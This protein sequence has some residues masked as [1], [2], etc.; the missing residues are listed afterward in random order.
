MLED[1]LKNH[2]KYP[3]GTK[4][5]AIDFVVTEY[6]NK[7]DYIKYICERAST[8]LFNSIKDELTKRIEDEVQSAFNNRDYPNSSIKVHVNLPEELGKTIA[9]I[10]LIYTKETI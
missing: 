9:S 8:Q 1:I 6:E 4:M 2:P 3:V 10:A 7:K 5:K